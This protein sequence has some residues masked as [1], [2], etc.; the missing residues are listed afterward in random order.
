MSQLINSALT[1]ILLYHYPYYLYVFFSKF[2]FE[3]FLS[4]S[5]LIFKNNENYLQY[6]EFTSENSFH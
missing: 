2:Y 6:L 4:F 3:Y 1:L 5:S